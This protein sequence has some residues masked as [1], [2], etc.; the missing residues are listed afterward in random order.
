MKNWLSPESGDCE[1]AIDTVPRT[2]GSRENS[3]LSFWPEPPVPV[4]V[5]SGQ[6]LKAEFSRDE[7]VDHPMKDHAVIEALA[8][9]LGDAGDVIGRKIRPQADDDVSFRGFENESLIAHGVSPFA[10][11]CCR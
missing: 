11:P 6:K 3:A 10:G 5:G 8:H 9:Q 4:P 7:A 1:R 2:C